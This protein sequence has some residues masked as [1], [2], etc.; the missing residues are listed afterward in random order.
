MVAKLYK[1]VKTEEPGNEAT[2]II[3]EDITVFYLQSTIKI[4]S[5]LELSDFIK[6]EGFKYEE[7]IKD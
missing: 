5:L 6:K 7:R 3:K 4:S 1:N 2:I